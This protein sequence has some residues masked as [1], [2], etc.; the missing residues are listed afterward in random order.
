MTALAV[1]E[2]RGVVSSLVQKPWARLVMVFALVQTRAR[3][4]AA[5]LLGALA[6]TGWAARLRPSPA[7]SVLSLKLSSELSSE[8][9]L[10]LGLVL[11]LEQKPG[12][13]RSS[14][15]HAVVAVVPVAHLPM[16]LGVAR[17]AVKAQPALVERC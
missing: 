11:S 12:V 8:L 2:F 9:G 5:M 4:A 1:R 17:S 6:G 7:S 3:R 10:E 14:E 16:L 13:A 15:Q